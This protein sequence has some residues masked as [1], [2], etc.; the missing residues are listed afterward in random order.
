MELG[1]AGPLGFFL[2]VFASEDEPGL[3][4]LELCALLLDSDFDLENPDPIPKLG[5]GDKESIKVKSMQVS[6]KKK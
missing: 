1:S 6:C 3:S 2:E 5:R 4:D